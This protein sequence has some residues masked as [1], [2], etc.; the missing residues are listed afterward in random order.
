MSQSEPTFCLVLLLHDPLDRFV[1][2]GV[3]ER[4]IAGITSLEGCT[5]LTVVNNSPGSAAL[6]RYLREV[7]A[8]QL[9]VIEA[10]ENV[11]VGPGYNLALKGR[12]LE[13]DY[14]VLLSSDTDV[15]GS[16]TLLR[17]HAA[18][19]GTSEVGL[20][21][22]MSVFEDVDYLNAMPEYGLAAYQA[23][24]RDRKEG[25]PVLDLT[26]SEIARVKAHVESSHGLLRP[27]NR[28]GFTF[29]L[30]KRAVWE[31]LGEFDPSFPYCYENIDYL[32]RAL[33]R[34]Y[35]TAVVRGVFVNHRRPLVRVLC[36]AGFGA[37]AE[38][39]YH[40]KYEESELA[41]YAKWRMPPDR[42][43]EIALHGRLGAQLRRWRRRARAQAGAAL[44]AAG[45][46]R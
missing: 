9:R 10:A 17:M 39:L 19:A 14:L 1:D 24:W 31:A 4:L 26:A 28:L 25:E 8:G 36:G 43:V 30:T 27:V 6:R 11:G 7:R 15:V 29:L 23:F 41:W 12:R 44:R 37:G 16:D 34:G 13:A 22:P 42:A 20:A 5:E 21:Q 3:A 46:R 2:A 32:V 40:E 33:R 35:Q 45:L 38:N 18:V